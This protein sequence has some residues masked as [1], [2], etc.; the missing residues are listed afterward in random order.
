LYQFPAE[1]SDSDTQVFAV[2]TP[3]LFAGSQTS[4]PYA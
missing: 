3:P 1:T 2:G 4:V